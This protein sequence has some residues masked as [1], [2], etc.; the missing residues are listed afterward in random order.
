MDGPQ[1]TVF[2]PH[3]LSVVIPVY[4]GETTLKAV[5]SEL[6]DFTSLSSTPGGHRFVITEIVLVNDNGTDDSDTVIRGLATEY[7]I[8][9]PVWLSRNFGQHAATLAGISSST[10]E[11]IVTLDEDG[12]HDPA[13]IGS[14]LDIALIEQADVVYGRPVNAPPHGALRN[15]ASRAA[16]GFA[17]KLLVSP[18]ASQYNSYR[19][20]VGSV[21][22]GMAAYAGAGAYLDVALGWVVKRY[23]TS[24]TTLRGGAR[25]SGYGARKTVGHFWRLVVSSGTRALRIVSALGV[26]LSV[27]GIVAVLWL[28][29]VKLTTGIDAEGWTSTTVLLLLASGAILFSLGVIAEYVGVSVNMAM[30][31]PGY[32]IVPDP[33]NGP[34]GRRT[35]LAR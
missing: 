21:A 19:L 2:A 25:K 10:A 34:L 17:N 27:F 13:D 14:F 16:K 23:A 6:M 33:A 4:K 3:K 15:L 5:V 35:S 1:E 24:P 20:M 12:Q 30:G 8:V 31:K 28:I 11:W 26:L 7:D 18:D 22:R 29:T 9:S 32:L